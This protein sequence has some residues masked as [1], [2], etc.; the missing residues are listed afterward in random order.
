MFIYVWLGRDYAGVLFSF[1]EEIWMKFILGFGEDGC[2]S[3]CPLQANQQL[4]ER[5]LNLNLEKI[6]QRKNKE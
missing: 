4:W 6:D 3:H 5:Y 2:H 1:E